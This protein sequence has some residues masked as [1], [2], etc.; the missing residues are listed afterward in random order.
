MEFD[1]IVLFVFHTLLPTVLQCLDLTGEESFITLIKTG[2]NSI[3][4]HHRNT[5]SQV[6]FFLCLGRGDCDIVPHME[7]KESDKPN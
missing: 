4:H 6:S 7:N 3:Y 5:G 2:I 1:N